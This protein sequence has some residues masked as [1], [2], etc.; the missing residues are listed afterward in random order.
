MTEGRS[1]ERFHSTPQDI[2]HVV[3]L[4]G[5]TSEYF[6]LRNSWGPG[7]GENGFMRLKQSQ[8]CAVDKTPADG[9]GCDGGPKEVTVCGSCGILYQVCE[10]RMT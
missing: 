10:R 2:N 8:A 3:H 5:Y 6:I 7:W 9:T 4:V 1:H